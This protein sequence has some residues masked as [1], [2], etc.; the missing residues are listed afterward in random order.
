MQTKTITYKKN[1]LGQWRRDDGEAEK[2]VTEDAMFREIAKLMTDDWI[3]VRTEG[4]TEIQMVTVE[5]K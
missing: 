4:L 3:V 2:N 1:Q 5:K